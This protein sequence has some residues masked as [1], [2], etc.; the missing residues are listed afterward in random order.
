M[1]ELHVVLARIVYLAYQER[2]S[3]FLGMVIGKFGLLDGLFSSE[4]VRR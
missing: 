3:L 2:E 4:E 1:K